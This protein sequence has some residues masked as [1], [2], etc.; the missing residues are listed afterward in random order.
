MNRKKKGLKRKAKIAA[1]TTMVSASILLG[2]AME[3]PYDLINSNDDDSHHIVIEDKQNISVVEAMVHRIPLII[4][5][6]LLIPMWIAGNLLLKVLDPVKSF[7]LQ[8][9]FTFLV[10]TICFVIAVKLLFPNMK[11]S[12]ILTRKNLIILTVSSL[13][14]TIINTYLTITNSDY[15]KY[16][17]LIRF[18]I[19]LMTLT[20][21]LRPFIILKR[22]IDSIIIPILTVFKEVSLI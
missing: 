21:M 15:R 10:M 16:T 3:D 20:F 19:G 14:I 9:L 13:G 1:A 17:L 22:K 2:A 5:V 4:R 18:V 8:W 12:E 11:L 6:L 7:F